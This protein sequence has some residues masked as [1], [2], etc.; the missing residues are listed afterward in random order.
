MPFSTRVEVGLSRDS[1]PMPTV[2]M[3]VP[4][5]GKILYRPVADTIR[6]EPIDD[7]S[8]PPT[9]GSISRPDTVALTPSTVCRKKPM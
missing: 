9:N 6:P 3:A 1:R 2:A 5:M 4:R 8:R 7:T